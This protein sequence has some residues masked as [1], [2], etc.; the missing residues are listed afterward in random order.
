MSRADLKTLAMWLAERG[1]A[2][3]IATDRR[4]SSTSDAFVEFVL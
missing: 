3:A 4:S 1:V 2:G